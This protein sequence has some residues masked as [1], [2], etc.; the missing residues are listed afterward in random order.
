[1]I[2]YIFLPDDDKCADVIP[3]INTLGE[4]GERVFYPALGFKVLKTII[5]EHERF[6]PKLEIITSE[7]KQI[8]VEEFFDQIS[9]LRTIADIY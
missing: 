4:S 9:H 5:R 6:V 1:M 2:Y 8:S 3:D 7:G